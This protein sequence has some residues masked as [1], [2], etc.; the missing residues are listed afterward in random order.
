MIAA[1]RASCSKLGQAI[2]IG[3]LDDLRDEVLRVASRTR[4]ASCAVLVARANA[5]APKNAE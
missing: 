3:C 5:W 1:R 2:R 4:R